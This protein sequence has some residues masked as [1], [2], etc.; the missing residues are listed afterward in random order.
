MG[1]GCIVGPDLAVL[2][3]TLVKKGVEE[4]AGL[5]DEQRPR[6]LGPK[7]A[8]KI[9]KLFELDKKDD[10]R[11]YVVRRRAGKK[12]KKPKIQRLITP[13]RLQRRRRFWAEKKRKLDMSKQLKEEYSKRVTEFIQQRKEVRAAHVA[14][15][16][17]QKTEKT[18]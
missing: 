13:Q 8:N 16:K 6:R 18:A 14:K 9:R 7:R 10:V 1:R 17:K 5:T 11:L 2:S 4:L 12:L 15:K 3:L